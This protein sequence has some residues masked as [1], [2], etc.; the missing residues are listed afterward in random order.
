MISVY[1]D[2]PKYDALKRLSAASGRPVAEHLREGVDLVLAEYKVRV[3]K[4]KVPK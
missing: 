1:V 3:A 2:P 4:P